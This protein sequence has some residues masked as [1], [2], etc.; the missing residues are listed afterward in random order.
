MLISWRQ[1][2][3]LFSRRL[4]NSIKI[5]LNDALI[6]E[7]NSPVILTYSF[8]LFSLVISTNNQVTR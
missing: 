3:V 8:S 5:T 1:S 4:E 7:I 2:F 6:P